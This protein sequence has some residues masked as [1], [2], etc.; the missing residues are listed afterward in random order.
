MA[1]LQSYKRSSHYRLATSLLQIP[2]GLIY[3]PCRL[4][5]QLVRSPETPSLDRTLCRVH[6]LALA[7]TSKNLC[8]LSGVYNYG[9]RRASRFFR[10]LMMGFKR[11]VC[12]KFSVCRLKICASLKLSQDEISVAIGLKDLS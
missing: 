2:C 6:T 5:I 1:H 3:G 9:S 4:N 7:R 12:K 8:G 11:I 10:S